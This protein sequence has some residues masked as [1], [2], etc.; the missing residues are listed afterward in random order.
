MLYIYSSQLHILHSTFP[1]HSSR[2]PRGIPR[3]IYRTLHKPC[4]TILTRVELAPH[5]A[6]LAEG[7]T[8]RRSDLPN[9]AVRVKL[10]ADSARGGEDGGVLVGIVRDRISGERNTRREG[11]TRNVR[12]AGS[13]L[14]F[15]SR[16]F[17]SRRL[18]CWR[19]CWMSR[20]TR[21][22]WV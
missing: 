13:R 5:G 8:D 18:W 2:T 12:L 1:L 7:S 6:L 10:L 4:N 21:G 14:C 9:G 15:C 20:R 22:L 19:A 17:C 16:R 3:P 11:G